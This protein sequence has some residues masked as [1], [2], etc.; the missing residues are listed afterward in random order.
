MIAKR[1]R[2]L[3]AAVAKELGITKAEAELKLED[4]IGGVQARG[5][6]ITDYESQIANVTAAERL[7]VTDPARFMEMLVAVN[8]EYSGYKKAAAAPA[9][10]AVLEPPTDAEP[11]PDYDLGNG[12][13]TYSLEGLRKRDAWAERQ[14]LARIEAK[15]GERFKP[16]EDQRRETQERAAAT[17]LRDEQTAQ[18]TKRVDRARKWP[19]FT[20]HEKDITALMDT[21][22]GRGNF[23]SF[24]DAYMQLVIPK[25]AGD[26][27]KIR[28]ETIAELNSQPRSSSAT[29]TVAPKADESRPKTTAEIAREVMASL[30]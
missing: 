19:Q 15:M 2:T 24:E 7:M 14:M 21:E 11:E 6:K 1:E 16:F 23:I 12:Q 22:R 25:L 13:K 4:V 30:G 29:S 20:E 8:P 17:A 9:Q 27:T 3:I 28:Q 5:S 18:L 10:A 26:R